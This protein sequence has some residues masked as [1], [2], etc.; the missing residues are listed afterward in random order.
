MGAFVTAQTKKMLEVTFQKK[1]FEGYCTVTLLKKKKKERR[2]GH[3]R[4]LNVKAS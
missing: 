4:D 1:I 3:R 2:G